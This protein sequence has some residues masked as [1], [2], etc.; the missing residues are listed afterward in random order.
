MKQININDKGVYDMVSFDE[1][2]V[3]LVQWEGQ[4]SIL[5]IAGGSFSL[6][7]CQNTD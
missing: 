4:L 2:H 3:V 1:E 7:E 5:K 6:I